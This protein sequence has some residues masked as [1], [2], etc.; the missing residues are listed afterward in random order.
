MDLVEFIEY[1]KER[2][3]RKQTDHSFRMSIPMIL[4]LEKIAKEQNTDKS[5]VIRYAIHYL[6]Q[7]KHGIDIY[8]P[9]VGAPSLTA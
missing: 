4:Q 6:L 7:H 1:E 2:K 9:A 8:H 3:I 5:T